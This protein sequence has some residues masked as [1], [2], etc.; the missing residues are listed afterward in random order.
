MQSGRYR[1]V[2]TGSNADGSFVVRSPAFTVE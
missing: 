2:V 1:V